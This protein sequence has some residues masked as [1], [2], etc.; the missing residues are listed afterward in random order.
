MTNFRVMGDEMAKGMGEGWVVAS[1]G[2]GT[3]MLEAASRSEDGDLLLGKGVET[4]ASIWSAWRGVTSA[5]S[6][7]FCLAPG[8]RV[9]TLEFKSA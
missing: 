1:R 9:Q 7:C 6:L 4:T 5:S 8:F 3:G 2:M